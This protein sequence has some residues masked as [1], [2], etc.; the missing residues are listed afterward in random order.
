MRR[1]IAR[2]LGPASG[3][4][5][6]HVPSR[7]ARA[8][9]AA[10]QPGTGSAVSMRCDAARCIPSPFQHPPCRTTDGW[11]TNERAGPRRRLVEGGSACPRTLDVW[12][13]GAAT[14]TC[15]AAM[16]AIE[17]NVPGPGVSCARGGPAAGAPSG[18]RGTPGTAE[19]RLGARVRA[20][21]GRAPLSHSQPPG[22]PVPGQDPSVR[23]PS[24]SQPWMA[25]AGQ[26]CQP[27]RA[28]AL[29]NHA[30]GATPPL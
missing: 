26:P 24:T 14:P 28:R 10:T 1:W 30:L 18:G 22:P 6:C 4:V 9:G 25:V 5:A 23:F 27:A 12:C 8:R 16:T 2:S 29:P 15:A 21:H 7:S 17:L 13:A 19:R 3:R 20:T 11:R